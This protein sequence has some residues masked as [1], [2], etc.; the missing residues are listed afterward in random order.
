SIDE[1][2][3]YN[4][5]LGAGEIAA[6]VTAGSAGKCAAPQIYAQ[7]GSVAAHTGDNVTFSAAASGTPQLYYQWYFNGQPV[8]SANAPSLSLT[9]VQFTDAGNYAVRV[10]NAF[11]AKL[12]QIA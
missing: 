5:A 2:S 10:T 1:V 9:S 3:V 6:V 7:P 8:N 11:G 4:R 12:S